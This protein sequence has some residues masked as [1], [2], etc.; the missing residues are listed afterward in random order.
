MDSH[1]ARERLIRSDLPTKKLDWSAYQELDAAAK[2]EQ[3]I[4]D[5]AEAEKR[6]LAALASLSR[7]L[8]RIVALRAPKYRDQIVEVVDKIALLKEQK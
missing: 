6:R 7:E 2:A 1:E 5:A 3:A 4:E 8:L